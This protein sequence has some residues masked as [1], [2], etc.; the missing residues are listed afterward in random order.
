MVSIRTDF[1]DLNNR[2]GPILVIVMYLWVAQMHC[3]AVGHVESVDW[4]HCLF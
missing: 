4:H 1:G 3:M 2:M